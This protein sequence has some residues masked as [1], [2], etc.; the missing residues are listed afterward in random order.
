MQVVPTVTIADDIALYALG[1]WASANHP[2]LL[3]HLCLNTIQRKS[4][5][6]QCSES[7]P[8]HITIHAGNPI[9]WSACTNCNLCIP[10]CPTSAINQSLASFNDV[11]RR[12]LEGTRPV[13][14]SCSLGQTSTDVSTTCLASLPWDLVAAAALGPGAVL[15]VQ[16][17]ETCPHKHLVKDV[18]ALV[19]KLKAFLGPD[20]FAQRVFT[21]VNQADTQDGFSK[22]MAMVAAAST[23]QAG[24]T[25]LSEA[26]EKPRMSSARA[27]LMEV[28]EQNLSANEQA[29]TD[30]AHASTLPVLHWPALIEE[31]CCSG[32]EI[33]V[34]M[35]PHQALAL[36]VP[37]CETDNVELQD[38]ALAQGCMA[39][40]EQVLIHQADRC[41]Q[42]GLCYLSCPEQ[43]L[44]GWR[45]VR[46]T[47]VPVLTTMPIEVAIC[48]QCGH[49]FKPIADETRCKICARPRVF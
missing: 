20:Q 40:N 26:E 29:G 8:Q 25:N 47:F 4:P 33:C 35:C 42:C 43:G 12:V 48:E 23:A 15:V 31:G 7:C 21:Q 18:K 24:M 27:L 6:A 16:P 32:C 28:I 10:A 1:Y 9:D 19:K 22:R 37:G 39:P 30:E 11:R 44:A 41:T 49:V 46:S 34:K 14:F 3:E 5:C 45:E 38:E 13:S 36:Y 2:A 17:C